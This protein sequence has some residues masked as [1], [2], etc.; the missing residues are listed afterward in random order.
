MTAFPRLSM[1]PWLQSRPAVYLSPLC[2][3]SLPRLL[4]MHG[5]SADPRGEVGRIEPKLI[6]RYQISASDLVC[7]HT[8]S[9]L[10]IRDVQPIGEILSLT[11][12]IPPLQPAIDEKHA[13]ITP[14]SVTVPISLKVRFI[15]VLDSG[16][17]SGLN[18]ARTLTVLR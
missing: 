9:S 15:F 3:L 18:H 17:Y 16:S 4:G 7:N 10:L 2:L 11:Y 6:L 12:P 8:L 14:P 1:T 5:H 13:L